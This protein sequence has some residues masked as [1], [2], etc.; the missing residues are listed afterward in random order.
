[1]FQTYI[2]KRM[3]PK[4]EFLLKKHS[5]LGVFLLGCQHLP[6]SSAL[7]NPWLDWGLSPL[8]WMCR[9]GAPRGEHL[10]SQWVSEGL[11]WEGT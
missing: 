4:V 11:C 9:Q 5:Q 1:M 2:S 10:E 8:S 3:M 7:E 6:S